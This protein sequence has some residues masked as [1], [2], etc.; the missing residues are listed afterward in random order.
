[1]ALRNLLKVSLATG[2][3]VAVGAIGTLH[4]GASTSEPA[5]IS[6]SSKLMQTANGD[7]PATAAQEADER[8]V[9]DLLPFSVANLAAAPADRPEEA[10]GVEPMFHRYGETSSSWTNM[11][12]FLGYVTY[13]VD[14]Y[15]NAVFAASGRPDPNVKLLTPTTGQSFTS[16][17]RNADG[18]A[19][20]TDDESAFYCGADDTIY[21]SQQFAVDLWKGVVTG[22][23]GQ[24]LT[25][26]SRDFAVAYVV[27]HEYAHN[28]QRELGLR[29]SV[30]G[31]AA[32][33]QQADCFAGAWA[34]AAS[35]WKMLD[36]GDIQEALSTAWLVGDDGDDHGTP[37]QRQAAVSL[38]FQGGASA[39]GAYSDR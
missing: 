2:T 8:T 29:S 12:E 38:G 30:M 17:C 21:L 1:M 20:V 18:T 27:A 35:A 9:A 15:W 7:R 32:F 10:K 14:V 33:E 31:T 19:A 25:P 36:P 22:P 16:A 28:V 6:A 39:C 24:R 13:A 3:L 37:A 5:S 4:L 23:L 11:R 26:A 34:A